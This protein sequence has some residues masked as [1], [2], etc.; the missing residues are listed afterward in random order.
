MARLRLFASVLLLAILAFPDSALG[1]DPTFSQ[2]HLNKNYL[3]PAYAGYTRNLSFGMFSR[4]QWI[5]LPG[6]FNTYAFNANIGCLPPGLGFAFQAYANQEGEGKLSTYNISGQVSYTLVL[7]DREDILAAGLGY[8]LGWKSIDWTK[9]TFSDQYLPYVGFLN[10]P[11]AV[12]LTNDVSSAIDDLSFGVR[13]KAIFNEK[14]HY[15]SAG[16]GVFHF[17]RPVE[18]FLNTENR[19]AARYTAHFFAYWQVKKNRN[20]PNY[21]SAGVIYDQ[22][23]DISTT[24]LLAF[25]DMGPVMK[26]GAGLRNQK[27][28]PLAED[29]NTL[30]TQLMVATQDLILSFSYDITLSGLP[31]PESVGTTEV[32]LVY[33]IQNSTLCKERFRDR[34]QECIWQ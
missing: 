17:N 24:T 9:L 29:I 19:L 5:N 21:L 26:V 28:V 34:T 13:Y 32:S 30:T 27:I 18:T 15:L 4:Q 11:S 16:A 8:G 7:N 20:R 33:I 10:Q 3:N 14:G 12:T 6:S 25:L 31:V 23:Q 22:Q 1:Q 2:F